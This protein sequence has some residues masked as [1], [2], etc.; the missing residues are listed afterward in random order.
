MQTG[1]IDEEMDTL[2]RCRADVEHSHEH[3][4]FFRAFA[5][6]VTAYKCYDVERFTACMSK[7]IRDFFTLPLKD[8]MAGIKKYAG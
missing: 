5:A 6:L 3:I 2:L 7:A 8:S 1:D 4:S